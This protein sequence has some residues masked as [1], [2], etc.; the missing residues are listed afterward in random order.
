MAKK[1]EVFGTKLPLEM[2]NDLVYAIRLAF[3]AGQ[4]PEFYAQ[5]KQL[6]RAVTYPA[7]F[8]EARNGLPTAARYEQIFRVEIIAAIKQH[9][10]YKPMRG[11]YFCGYFL[12]CVQRHMEKHWETYYEESKAV[13]RQVFDVMAGLSQLA[14]DQP[15]AESRMTILVE[16]HRTASGGGGRK[17]KAATTEAQGSLF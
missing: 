13:Q 4:D 14:A 2:V 12:K 17:K 11:S 1:T 10:N 16:L 6:V 5:R 3:Y 9:G 8:L 15:K 7:T